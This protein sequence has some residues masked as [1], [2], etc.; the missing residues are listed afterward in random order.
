[1]QVLL[2]NLILAQLKNSLTVHCHVYKIP[3][4]I[5]AIMNVKLRYLFNHVGYAQLTK[6]YKRIMHFLHL[7]GTYPIQ[8]CKFR[9]CKSMHLHTFK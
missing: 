4:T 7:E 1:V 8:K 5:M 3:V 2:D 9:V 6:F